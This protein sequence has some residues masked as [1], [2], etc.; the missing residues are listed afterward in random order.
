MTRNKAPTP[1]PYYLLPNLLQHRIGRDKADNCAEQTRVHHRTML[2]S[3]V[4][5]CSACN[6]DSVLTASDI[7]SDR[8][9]AQNNKCSQL[10]PNM[11]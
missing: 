2:R 10:N 6:P 9:T 11:G 3:Q 7:F 4:A 1:A 8:V 5:M